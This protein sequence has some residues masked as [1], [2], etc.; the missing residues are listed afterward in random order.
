MSINCGARSIPRFLSF[1]DNKRCKI[2]KVLWLSFFIKYNFYCMTLLYIKI[3]FDIPSSF[4]S[5]ST[6]FVLFVFFKLFLILSFLFLITINTLQ[7]SSIFLDGIY[8]APFYLTKDRMLKLFNN[9]H[10]IKDNNYK[11][12]M[13]VGLLL[14]L[15]FYFSLYF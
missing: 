10:I 5:F 2:F 13:T 11:T 8:L 6:F 9:I 3:F 14:R 12:S 7:F 4:L 1:N 15:F